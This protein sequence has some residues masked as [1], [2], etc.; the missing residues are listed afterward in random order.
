MF[1]RNLRVSLEKTVHENANIVKFGI[2]LDACKNNKF[3]RKR[4]KLQNNGH[5]KPTLNVEEQLVSLK[6][7]I[8]DA[9]RRS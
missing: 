1:F 5:E 6:F 7:S 9:Q 3:K 2:L 8:D 4:V